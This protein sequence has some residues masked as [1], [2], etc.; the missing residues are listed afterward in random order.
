[1][2]YNLWS[3]FEEQAKKYSTATPVEN[4]DYSINISLQYNYWFTETPKVACSTIKTI[5]QKMELNNPDL[6]WENFEDLHDRNFSPLLKPSQL[7]NLDT[8]LEGDRLFKFCFSRNPYT[9]LLSSYIDKVIPPKPEKKYV[10]LALGRNPDQLEQ[11][12]TFAEFVHVISQQKTA[13]MN[14]HW[15]LQYYQTFQKN[16]QYDFI[17]KIENLKQDLHFVLNKI[18]PD[19]QRFISNEKRH[20]TNANELLSH[21]YTPTLINN[22]QKI[23]EED[24]IYFGYA[25]DFKQALN[26]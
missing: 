6:H 22:V 17:G 11:K 16:I 26:S 24:F 1:M 20:A 12:I 23:Y 13:S 25:F 3:S 9:R 10:L 2:N 19:Y 18:N 14:S 15:K 4:F 21:Y 7:E 5:L 8:F